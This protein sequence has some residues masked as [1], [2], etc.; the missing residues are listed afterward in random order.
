MVR[1]MKLFTN[2]KAVGRD[3]ALEG[4]WPS[5]TNGYTKLC[6]EVSEL[7]AGFYG[8]CEIPLDDHTSDFVAKKQ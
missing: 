7:N 4:I 3:E 2:T 1:E 8:W 5:I 6:R